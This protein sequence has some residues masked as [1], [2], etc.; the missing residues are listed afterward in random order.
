MASQSTA[1]KAPPA[2][3]GR[4]VRTGGVAAHLQRVCAGL[5]RGDPDGRHPS[6]PVVS[7]P[8]VSRDLGSADVGPSP[9][10]M[11]VKRRYRSYL[12]SPVAGTT[13][14]GTQNVRSYRRQGRL[15]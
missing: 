11:E 3:P 9:P 10:E 2:I 5:L 1:R 4:I 12:L 8:K 7:I 14:G 15:A 6:G 13:E